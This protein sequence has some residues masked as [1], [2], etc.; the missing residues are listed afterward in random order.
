V[1]CSEVLLPE[2][3]RSE[4]L[5]SEVLGSEVLCEEMVCGEMACGEMAC[6]EM[7]C[8]CEELSCK[9]LDQIPKTS[10]L[11][12]N[13]T[14]RLGGYARSNKGT[15]IEWVESAWKG[16]LTEFGESAVPGRI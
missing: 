2:A 1:P 6:G 14:T 16:V 13:R 10:P 8:E 3:L 7:V 5:R 9:E 12:A 4:D 11:F 15:C